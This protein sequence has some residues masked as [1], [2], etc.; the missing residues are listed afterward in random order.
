MATSPSKKKPEAK[1]AP[2]APTKKMRPE[3]T[4]SEKDKAYFRRK[5]QEEEM[6]RKMGQRYD[7]IMPNPEFAKGGAVKKEDKDKQNDLTNRRSLLEERERLL[8][9]REKLKRPDR[10]I[11]EI[12]ASR[13][14]VRPLRA[15]SMEDKTRVMDDKY[16]KPG[17][18]DKNA[19]AAWDSRMNY[20]ESRIEDIN[21]RLKRRPDEFAMGGMAQKKMSKVMK[22]YKA[23]T[24]HSGKGGKVV[25][26]PKQ[27]VAIGLSEA[28]RMKK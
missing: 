18:G 4:M 25:K 21:T 5:M 26:S 1:K 11:F 3:D 2:V 12:A 23:G 17:Q 8:A 15:G 13:G 28:R 20:L 24:L 6:M 27:A 9:Q 14:V 10:N 22:E 7:E 16:V 19:A